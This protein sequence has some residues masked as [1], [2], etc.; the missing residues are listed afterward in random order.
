MEIQV[1]ILD[2]SKQKIDAQ[3]NQLGK[4]INKEKLIIAKVPFFGEVKPPDK[5][6]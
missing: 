6:L 1:H 3:L 4:S 5:N 2:V